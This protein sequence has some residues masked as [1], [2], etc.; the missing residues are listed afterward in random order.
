MFE[1]W[2]SQSPVIKT[3]NE[4]VTGRC[5]R[6]TRT[7][8]LVS[9]VVVVIVLASTSP[10]Q[11][12]TIPVSYFTTG[13]FAGCDALG[14]G[15]GFTTCTEGNSILRYGFQPVTSVDL[16]DA[17]ASVVDYGTFQMSGDSANPP[18]GDIF[19][20]VTF[21][22]SL[23]QTG[24]SA[25]SQNLVGSVGGSVD[26]NSGGLTW[27]PVTPS[28][29]IGSIHW[30]IALEATNGSVRIDPPGERGAAGLVSM[31]GGTAS[32]VPTRVPEP[33]SIVLMGLGLAA[34]ARRRRRTPTK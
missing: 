17:V 15:V 31:I 4:N 29:N 2:S 23:F 10:A 12:A 8:L 34:L 28:W 26:V 7:L 24:P 32:T 27:G 21:T 11:A 19:S 18:P 30:T 33:S 1:R 14:G 20:G 13:V 3:V 25:G 16:I 9:S 22:L 6:V 5:L